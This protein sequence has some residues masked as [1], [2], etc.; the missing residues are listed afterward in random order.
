MMEM[1]VRVENGDGGELSEN[2]TN[3]S[4]LTMARRLGLGKGS[5]EADA[6]AL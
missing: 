1:V 6:S 2:S 5:T 3:G 4:A